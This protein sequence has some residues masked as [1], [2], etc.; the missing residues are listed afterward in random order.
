MN[1]FKTHTFLVAFLL[2]GFLV[3]LAK[4]QEATDGFSEKE[5]ISLQKELVEADELSSK[6]RMRLPNPDMAQGLAI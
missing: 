4:S 3:G 1:T 6:T 5:I 2:A